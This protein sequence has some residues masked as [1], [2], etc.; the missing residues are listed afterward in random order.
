MIR[1]TQSA[2]GSAPS[3]RRPL[4]SAQSLCGMELTRKEEQEPSS[5]QKLEPPSLGR[6]WEAALLDA[7]LGLSA[8]ALC[9]LVLLKLRNLPGNP[10]ALP[11]RILPG[12]LVL[13]VLMHLAYHVLCIGPS[14]RPSER[15]PWAS[16]S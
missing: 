1:S 15:M 7:M 13:A 2:D 6:L 10:F 16:R 4:T 11:G 14:G 12:L 9:A 5:E 3:W 8:W